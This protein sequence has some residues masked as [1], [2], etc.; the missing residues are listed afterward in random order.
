MSRK[1]HLSKPKKCPKTKKTMF[2]KRTQ[3]SYA[4]MRVI[5][6]TT[7]NMFDL[8]TY[9]CEFCKTWHFGHKSYY[10]QKLARENE[11]TGLSSNIS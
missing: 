1:F 2:K 7:T 9:V 5:S 6:N 3:A 11:Q 10:E 8:H 4:M